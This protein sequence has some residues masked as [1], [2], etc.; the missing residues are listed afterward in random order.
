[1]L[2]LAGVS[3]MLSG[4]ITFVLAA[5]G[6]RPDLWLSNYWLA[7]GAVVFL[8]GIGMYICSDLRVK[9]PNSARKYTYIGWSLFIVAGVLGKYLFDAG[10]P[11][12]I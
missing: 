3:S 9:R 7:T 2:K 8:S 1:M 10:S 6:F 12:G 11:V 5:T 4:L